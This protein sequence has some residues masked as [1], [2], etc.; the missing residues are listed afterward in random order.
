MTVPGFVFNPMM[1]AIEGTA[2]G[3][4]IA[5]PVGPAAALCIRRSISIG[6]VAGYLTGLGAALGDAVFGAAA[7]FGLSFVEQFVAQ[8]E[9]CLRGI[10]GLLLG[11]RGWRPVR[12]PPRSVGR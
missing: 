4:V 10:G 2:I 3:F 11:A 7:A 5:V 6:A 12:H 1:L 8:N 9:A